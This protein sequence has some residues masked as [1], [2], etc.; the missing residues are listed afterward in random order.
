[1]NPVPVPPGYF[2]SCLFAVMSQAVME[3]PLTIWECGPIAGQSGEGKKTVNQN[4]TSSLWFASGSV[5][6]NS[7]FCFMLSEIAKRGRCH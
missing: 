1:M 6:L 3:C 5:P 4:L 2:H 7:F